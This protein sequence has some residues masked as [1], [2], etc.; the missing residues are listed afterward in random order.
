MLAMDQSCAS[1]E[2][3]SLDCRKKD[4]SR[5]ST[6]MRR[7]RAPVELPVAIVN[8]GHEHA[9]T[10]WAASSWRVCVPQASGH[11]GTLPLLEAAVGCLPSSASPKSTSISSSVVRQS[12]WRS[13]NLDPLP[14]LC[15]FRTFPIGT[16]YVQRIAIHLACCGPGSWRRHFRE[17]AM[18]VVTLRRLDATSKPVLRATSHGH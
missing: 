1:E 10:H 7:A 3:E 2:S 16:A 17:A 11:T 13:R 9:R 5:I 12:Q 15:S 6:R 18:V 8:C 4:G 14:F